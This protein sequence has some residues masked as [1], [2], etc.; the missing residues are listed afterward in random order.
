MIISAWRLQTSSKFSG[1]EFKEIHRKTPKQMRIPPTRKYVVNG[2]KSARIVQY[3][4]SDAVR[5]QEN[6]YALQQQY[7]Q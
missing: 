7:I 6:K 1:Q 5:W 2:T 3:L 4:A